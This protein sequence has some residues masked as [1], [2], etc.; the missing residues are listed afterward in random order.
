LE[1]AK[2]GFPGS[3]LKGKSGRVNQENITSPENMTMAEFCICYYGAG[4]DSDFL[5]LSFQTEP[6]FSCSARELKL[7]NLLL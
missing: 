2:W 4:S 1:D 7:L 3:F 6:S 5:R